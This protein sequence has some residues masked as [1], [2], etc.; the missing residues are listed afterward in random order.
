MMNLKIFVEKQRKKTKFVLKLIAL[1]RT[2]R[3]IVI[4]RKTDEINS[5]NI[6]LKQIIFKNIDTLHKK[7]NEEQRAAVKGLA[8]SQLKVKL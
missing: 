2:L 3:D 1:E 5:E 6:Y 7:E 4:A 8:E